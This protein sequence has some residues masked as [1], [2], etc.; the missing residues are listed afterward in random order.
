[1][2]LS[3]NARFIRIIFYSAVQC[4]VESDASNILVGTILRKTLCTLLKHKAFAPGFGASS[5][6]L[7]EDLHRE[8]QRDLQRDDRRDDRR[9]SD[10]Q[11]GGDSQNDLH[12]QGSV[13]PNNVQRLYPLVA[14]WLPV[15]TPR[16][17]SSHS[18][19]PWAAVLKVIMLRLLVGL[20]G[21]P[22]RHRA[23]SCGGPRRRP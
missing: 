23:A 10:L 22:G 9:D 17:A 6:D 20:A 8:L 4:L 5:A 1:M 16:R 13:S 3:Q 2:F 21:G 12:S 15:H 18:G 11:Q 14:R 7:N 19:L